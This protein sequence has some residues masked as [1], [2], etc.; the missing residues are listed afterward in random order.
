LETEGTQR[1]DRA[2]GP[3]LHLL[4][5]CQEVLAKPY[6]GVGKGLK[7]DTDSAIAA[8][9]AAAAIAAALIIVPADTS[10]DQVGGATNR[11]N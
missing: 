9:V 8:V 7:P 11:F 5:L 3:A 4:V 6:A 1:E 2:I 10:I